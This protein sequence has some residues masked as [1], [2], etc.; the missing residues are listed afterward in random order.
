MVLPLS[1]LSGSYGGFVFTWFPSGSRLNSRNAY[2]EG[3]VSGGLTGSLIYLENLNAELDNAGH[4]V[5]GNGWGT[6][7]IESDQG[8]FEGKLVLKIRDYVTLF[9]TFTCHGSGMSD[10]KLLKGTF[11]VDVV[12]VP[13]IWKAEGEILD[14][15]EG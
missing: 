9:G 10:E 3:I 14:P 6:V 13:A 11:T 15:H 12:T 8:N 2:H 7:T 5:N 1:C 4:Y